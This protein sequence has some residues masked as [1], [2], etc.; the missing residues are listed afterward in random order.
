MNTSPIRSVVIAALL[1]ATGSGIGYADHNPLPR[2]TVESVREVPLADPVG[3][4]GVFELAFKPPT[5]DEVLVQLDDGQAI[6]IVLTGTQ[7][8][9]AGQRVHVVADPKGVRIEPADDPTFFQP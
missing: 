1:A 5:A 9:E 2:G 6:R 8:F 7:I 4:A 3:F